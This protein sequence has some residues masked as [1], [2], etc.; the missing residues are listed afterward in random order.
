MSDNNSVL[1][2]Y[3]EGD[4]DTELKQSDKKL[5]QYVIHCILQLMK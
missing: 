5:L 4:S 3:Y 1:D 2:L